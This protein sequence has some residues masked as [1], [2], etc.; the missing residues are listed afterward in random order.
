MQYDHNLQ[1]LMFGPSV[2]AKLRELNAALQEL[3]DK[4]W[5]YFERRN[6]TISQEVSDRLHNHYILN[7]NSDGILFFLL[8]D[9]ELDN[10]IKADCLHTV[11]KIIG[12]N[13]RKF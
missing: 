9:S 12:C 8:P 1:E 4:H 13:K 2:A 3:E 7:F 11:E 6:S 10:Q 5:R